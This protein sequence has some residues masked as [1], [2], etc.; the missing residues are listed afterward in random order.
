MPAA[1][2][3]A[4][5]AQA[6]AGA[7]ITTELGEVPTSEGTDS[8]VLK[9]ELTSPSLVTGAATNNATIN[10]RR[11]RAGVLQDVTATIT[12]AAGTNLPAE[13][14]VALP[15]TGSPYVAQGDVFEAVQVQNSSGL[16]LPAGVAVE[17]E[18]S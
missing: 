2:T 12:L 8:E 4:L 11:L 13:T 10:V 7:T 17:V 5:P 14:P 1:L 3:V 9:V 18:L 6:A 15:I 16:A